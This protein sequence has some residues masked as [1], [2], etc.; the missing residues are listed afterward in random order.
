M[1]LFLTFWVYLV[2]KPH[3]AISFITL[4]SSL[5][6]NIS[7][8]IYF[9]H[10]AWLQMNG[11]FSDFVQPSIKIILLGVAQSVERLTS[12]Q[13]MI[14]RSVSSSPVSSSVL[15]AQSLELALDSLSAPPP[16]MP[17]LSLSLSV[18]NK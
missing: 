6:L 10:Q 9:I 12:A 11:Y 13:V 7:L 18:K 15:T 5:L 3:K 2:Y 17:C 14:S 4:Y 1:L 8:I 16:L